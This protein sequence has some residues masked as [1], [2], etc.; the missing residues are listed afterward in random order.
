MKL[1]Y[2][3]SKARRGPLVP[4]DPSKT[5]VT[6][7]LD[8]AALGYL[9]EMIDRSGGGSMENVV[10]TVLRDLMALCKRATIEEREHFFKLA[11]RAADPHALEILTKAGVRK[12]PRSRVRD[13]LPD[14]GSGGAKRSQRNKKTHSRGAVRLLNFD[15]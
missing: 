9:A 15:T 8:N 1:K 4:K 3:F 14:S 6:I 2:D 12:S 11:A 10:N 7:R 13:N 5:L